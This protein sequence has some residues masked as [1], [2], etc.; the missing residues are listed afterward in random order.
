MSRQAPGPP[1]AA[2]RKALAD[3]LGQI[4]GLL[5]GSVLVR[6]MRCGKSGCAC[7][8]D[9]PVLHGP[10]VQWTRTANGKTVTKYLS[11]D[12][13]ERYQPWF[14]NAR[15]LKDLVAKLEVVSLQALATAEGWST[16]PTPPGPTSGP[17]PEPPCCGT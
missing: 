3:A 9:P 6:H 16:E 13:L 2:T 15:R 10:Y 7:R 4:D 12:Q 1:F 8:A 11:E 14:D 17:G 5:P